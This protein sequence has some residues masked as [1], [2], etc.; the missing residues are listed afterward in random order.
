MLVRSTPPERATFLLL[1]TTWCCHFI[2]MVVVFL[3]FHLMRLG[4]ES[5]LRIKK[6]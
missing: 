4:H 5:I 2:I 3:L 6:K 1:E